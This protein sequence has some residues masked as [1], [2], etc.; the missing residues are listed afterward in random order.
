M[1]LEM[2]RFAG[3]F[4]VPPVKQFRSQL[5]NIWPLDGKPS[6]SDAPARF[7]PIAGEIVRRPE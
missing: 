1:R 2:A 5:R 3:G 7:R 4:G 6:G